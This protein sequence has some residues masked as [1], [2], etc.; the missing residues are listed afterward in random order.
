MAT[1][2]DKYK[3]EIVDQLMKEFGYSSRM[4]VP[5]LEKIVFN[6]CDGDAITNKKI[7]GHAVSD[8]AAIT[9]QK[10]VVT[11]ARKSIAGFK[12]REGWPIG[13]MVTLRGERMY[14]MLERL[15]VIAI[16]RIR[17][18]RG[19]NPK[20][21]DSHGNYNFGIK[22]QIVFPELDYD[23]IDTLRGMNI[24]FVTSTKDASAA[25]ALLRAFGLPLKKRV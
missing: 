4:Q 19:L 7:I 20:G 24:T 3:N 5:K 2:E 13:C 15:I 25:E 16:P 22:E 18:F 21:F 23:K 6:M 10:P 8:L 1:F 11:K 12:V 14:E 9:G 17:D